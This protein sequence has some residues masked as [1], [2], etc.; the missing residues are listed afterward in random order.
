ML[1]RILD[2]LVS[3]P[4]FRNCCFP[5]C[6]A[7]WSM[8]FIK[9]LS[10]HGVKMAHLHMYLKL[11]SSISLHYWV[12]S[13]NAVYP[14]VARGIKRCVSIFPASPSARTWRT[15][16]INRL[17]SSTTAHYIPPPLHVAIS[18]CSKMYL[19][20]EKKW[21]DVVGVGHQHVVYQWIA[22]SCPISINEGLSGGSSDAVLVFE[23]HPPPSSSAQAPV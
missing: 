1:W 4:R 23:P 11:E 7:L 17:C 10:W 13:C 12:I 19:V 9:S 5:S 18:F 8:I 20:S 3:L 15:W 16:V 21:V 14:A 6:C 2:A 22:F